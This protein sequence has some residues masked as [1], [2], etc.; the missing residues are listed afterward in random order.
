MKTQTQ[1]TLGAKSVLLNGK[2]ILRQYICFENWNLHLIDLFE[3]GF[4]SDQSLV[5]IKI[6]LSG[7]FMHIIPGLRMLRKEAHQEF[8]TS[9][10]KYIIYAIYHGHFRIISFLCFIRSASQAKLQFS[11]QSPMHHV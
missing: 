11:P 9:Y 6:V 2:K 5:F 4:L 3:K 10:G 1:N 8:Q 7:W